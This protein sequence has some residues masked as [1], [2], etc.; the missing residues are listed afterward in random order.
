MRYTLKLFTII[1]ILTVIH[2]AGEQYHAQDH[3]QQQH[4]ELTT[5]RLQRVTQDVKPTR[6][7][8]EFED[9]N[10]TN[11]P[12]HAKYLHGVTLDSETVHRDDGNVKGQNGQHVDDVQRSF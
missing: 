5:A 1:A 4:E 9:T 10:H 12:Q 11:D 3:K 7:P 2:T 6:V 8:R